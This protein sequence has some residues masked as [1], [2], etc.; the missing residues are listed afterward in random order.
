MVAPVLLRRCL[1]LQIGASGGVTP[2]RAITTIIPTG[3][4]PN[5]PEEVDQGNILETSKIQQKTLSASNTLHRVVKR[6]VFRLSLHVSDFL[7]YLPRE[8][9]V[10]EGPTSSRRISSVVSAHG[11]KPDVELFIVTTGV[12]CDPVN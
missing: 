12:L 8:E 7:W 9:G 2:F 4:T 10:G 5:L 11:F 1:P 3:R 6:D